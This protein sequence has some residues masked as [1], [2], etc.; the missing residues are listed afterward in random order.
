MLDDIPNQYP[1]QYSSKLMKE[2]EA[3]LP[4]TLT[5]EQKDCVKEIVQD[6][7]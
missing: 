6:M 7:S 5:K 4:F 1:I 2:Q 3:K